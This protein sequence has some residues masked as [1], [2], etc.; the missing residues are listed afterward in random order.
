M[1]Q[2]SYKIRT[3]SICIPT[4]NRYNLLS[5]C[6]DSIVKQIQYIKTSWAVEI[7]ISDNSSSESEELYLDLISKYSDAT[8]RYYR[9]K[10]VL[11]IDENML[12]VKN[13]AKGQYIFYLGDDDAL[14]SDAL[15][16]IVDQL[17]RE[18]DVLFLNGIVN[19]GAE[20]N[21]SYYLN[22]DIVNKARNEQYFY[23]RDKTHFGMFVVKVS[24]LG[25]D[26]F[27]LLYGADHAY[28]CFW[29][30]LLQDWPAINHKILIDP[31]PRVLLNET[32]KSYN[33]LKVYYQ[34]IFFDLALFKR[35]L[36]IGPPQKFVCFFERKHIK[37]I[38][39][40]RFLVLL[41]LNGHKIE[42][43]NDFQ[44]A[45]YKQLK[46][47]IFISNLLGWLI[48]ECIRYWRSISNIFR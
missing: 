5:K 47:K 10:D 24:L 9:H 3:L 21:E 34:S 45:L 18:P 26:K 39:S 2:M 16:A 41:V 7:C 36:P 44:P 37:K 13:M 1:G 23:L 32:K 29:L 11:S 6:L 42:E 40:L 31:T 28:T 14:L 30:D 17:E 48:N 27:K 8:I 22:P 33:V 12:Y 15:I 20:H 38:S 46:F 25:D 4:Y 43:I 35:W 19:K